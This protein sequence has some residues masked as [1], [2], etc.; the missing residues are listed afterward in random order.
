M[1]LFSRRPERQVS[2]P[3][4]SHNIRVL[5]IADTHGLVDPRI[6]ALGHECDLI[7]HA[8]DIGGNEV[9][10]SLQASG[11][12]WLAV[13][14]NNDFPG[15]WSDGWDDWLPERLWVELPSGL[16][17]LLHGHQHNPVNARHAQLRAG[18]VEARAVVYGHSH[19]LVCDLDERPWVLN[20]GAAGRVRTYG[21]PSCILLHIHGERWQPEPIRFSS[22]PVD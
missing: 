14:G 10:Q 1:S 18:F 9:I 7:L 15:R 21:G 16:I 3:G 8:G 2:V 12:P 5:L 19:R 6:L 4:L 13:R 20:P 22:L 17:G 11:R